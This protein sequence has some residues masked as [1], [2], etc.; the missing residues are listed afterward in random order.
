MD[1]FTKAKKLYE[2]GDFNDIYFHEELRREI[3]EELGIE[4]KHIGNI[5]PQYRFAPQQAETKNKQGEMT[6]YY[7]LEYLC[8]Y[9][10]GDMQP[11]DD[12]IEAKWVTKE[13]MKNI[14]L[15]PP[16]QEMYRDLGWL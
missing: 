11:D 12:L 7:F 14:P 15:T 5:V 3:R 8:E 9:A 10:D 16:S 13:E 6:H 1:N 2:Q 4:I